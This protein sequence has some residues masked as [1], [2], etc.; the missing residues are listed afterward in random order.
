MLYLKQYEDEENLNCCWMQN[1]LI[2]VI[3]LFHLQIGDNHHTFMLKWGK[4]ITKQY[5]WPLCGLM[6]RNLTPVK[7]CACFGLLHR[8]GA[9]AGFESAMTSYG[10]KQIIC[11]GLARALPNLS[12]AHVTPLQRFFFLLEYDFFSISKYY[13][14]QEY[15]QIGLESRCIKDIIDMHI[16]GYFSCS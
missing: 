2:T 7:T 9:G 5:L 14:Y 11:I 13:S 12:S 10:R 6:Q 15:I 4:M 8:P 3:L 1:P 16:N